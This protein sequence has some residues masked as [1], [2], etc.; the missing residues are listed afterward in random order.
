MMLS[1]AAAAA[2]FLTVS[3]LTLLGKA[4]K[5]ISHLITAGHT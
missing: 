2:G 5:G 4:L 1:V 3:L